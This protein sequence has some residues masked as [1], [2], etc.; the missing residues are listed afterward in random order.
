M[1]RKNLFITFSR[2]GKLDWSQIFCSLSFC[3]GETF[4]DIVKF[5]RRKVKSKFWP[6][7]GCLYWRDYSVFLLRP[8]CSLCCTIGW[9]IWHHYHNF[10]LIPLRQ[11][12]GP[13]VPYKLI[14][15]PKNASFWPKT[16]PDWASKSHIYEKYYHGES[17]L[18]Y[19]LLKNHKTSPNGEQI[20]TILG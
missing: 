2:Q 16:T 4:L 13:Y 15:A 18:R 11:K 17:F 9:V 3:L 8:L 12:I 5:C 10:F 20:L 7:A 6:D 1:R 19:I 14:K